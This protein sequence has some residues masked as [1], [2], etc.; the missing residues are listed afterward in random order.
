MKNSIEQEKFNPWNYKPWWCQPWSILM[1]GITIISSSWL[2]FKIVWL[3]VIISI[4]ILTWMGF[5][6]VVWPKLM[7]ESRM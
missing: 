4:P 3:T 1:T 7:A 2:V 6:L 5:F